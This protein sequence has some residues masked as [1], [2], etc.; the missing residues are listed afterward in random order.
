[1]TNKTCPRCSSTDRAVRNVVMM[2]D[3]DRYCPDTWHSQPEPA[4]QHVRQSAVLVPTELLRQLKHYT[5][6]HLLSFPSCGAPTESE[7][8]TELAAV[9][10]EK[11]ES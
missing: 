8:E 4:T 7:I 1:M 6:C 5:I 10:P 9:V 3:A 11:Y 2:L